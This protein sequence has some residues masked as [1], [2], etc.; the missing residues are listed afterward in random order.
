MNDVSY[1]EA[2]GVMLTIAD[3]MAPEIAT[4]K[5]AS[6]SAPPITS[7]SREYEVYQNTMMS[8][9]NNNYPNINTLQ[10]L[11]KIKTKISKD[12]IMI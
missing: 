11:L 1:A 8:N 3:G 2:M 6:M 12:I 10:I 4:L 5:F 7:S 9:K